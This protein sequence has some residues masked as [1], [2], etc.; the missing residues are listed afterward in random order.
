[1]RYGTKIFP[2]PRLF[3]TD[4]A[5]TSRPTIDKT[6]TR[7][8]RRRMAQHKK[9]TFEPMDL[10]KLNSLVE[11]ITVSV[12]KM[13]GSIPQPIDLFSKTDEAGNSYPPGTQ[14]TREDVQSAMQWCFDK[15]GGGIY[16]GEAVDSNNLKM[17]WM[18][19]LPPA[20]VPEKIPPEVA[21]RANASTSVPVGGSIPM[22]SM[23]MGSGGFGGYAPQPPILQPGIP[24]QSATPQTQFQP[25]FQNPFYGSMGR[26]TDRERSDENRVRQLEEMVQREREE[27]IRLEHS[28]RIEKQE[29]QHTADMAAFREELRRTTEQ[30][31]P[32]AVDDE[33]AQL[34]AELRRTQED[35][36][37]RNEFAEAERRHSEQMQLLRDEIRA[38]R[39]T[40]MAS[41]G[42]DP[43]LE[44]MKENTRAQTE[45]SRAQLELARAQIVSPLQIAELLTKKGDG[46]QEMVRG[47]TDSFKNVM[48]LQNRVFENITQLS[49]AGQQHPAIEI[50]QNGVE[51]GAELGKQWLAMQRDRSIADSRAQ[52]QIAG[53]NAQAE[54]LRTQAAYFASNPGKGG[55][56]A[57]APA[58]AAAAQETPSPDSTTNGNGKAP[59][60]KELHDR[61]LFGPL[62]DDVEKLRAHVKNDGISPEDVGN[63]VLT[64]VSMV[65]EQKINVPAFQLFQQDRFPELVDL[66]LPLSPAAFKEEIVK[67]LI[68]RI[69]AGPSDVEEPTIAGEEENEPEEAATN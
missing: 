62:F 12:V 5:H 16:Q 52:A 63:A 26:N 64:A 56:L 69:G 36:Q 43:L 21:A 54:A 58:P 67:C 11:P 7:T 46:A 49:T 15:W 34:R 32:S 42:P 37:R 17:S 8:Y 47:I 51:K 31:R 6:I 29:Q 57:G 25:S 44:F 48:D 28:A 2:S 38:I 61:E 50:L 35:N 18:F 60:S 20:H 13:R 24:Q 19:G 10:Q 41:K 40:A 23:P 66:L 59:N 33:V 68:T 53:A 39:E 14:F 27:R 55:A 45:A 30:K 3:I 1:M 65:S 4:S 22:G 9:Q